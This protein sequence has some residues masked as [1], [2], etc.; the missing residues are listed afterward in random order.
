[1]Y[2]KSIYKKHFLLCTITGAL[3]FSH[4]SSAYAAAPLREVSKIEAKEGK[5]TFLG[6][7]ISRDRISNVDAVGKDSVATVTK[8]EMISEMIS[9]SATKGG[10]INAKEINAKTMI[11][12]LQIAD[13][14]INLEDSVVDV[15]GN[16]TSYGISFGFLSK[17]QTITFNE[18]ILTNTKL[19]VKD[20]IGIVGPLSSGKVKLKNSE[21]RSDVLLQNKSMPGTDPVT[22]TLT[23]DRS[24][25]E[26]RARTLQSNTTV[27]N[28]NND[29]KWLLKISK[30]EVDN[31][32]I[33]A[34]FNYK[35]LDIKKRAHSTVSVLNL[36]SSSIIFDT[37]IGEQY[38]T[39]TVGRGEVIDTPKLGEGLGFGRA[40]SEIPSKAPHDASNEAPSGAPHEAPSTKAVY[41]ATGSAKIYFNAK[42]SD[43]APK[44]QQKADH[45]LV[46]GDVSGTTAIHFNSLLKN[47][48]SNAEDEDN[49]PLNMRGLSLVQVSGKANEKSFK[50][51][52]GYTTMGG[53]P[54]KY[55]LNVYGP[56]S[57]RGKAHSGQNLLGENKDFWDFRLQSATLDREG[58]IKALV[59]QVASYLVMPNAL[60]SAGLADVNNQNTLLDNAQTT[61]RTKRGIVFSSYGN[62]ITLSSN[63]SPLQYGYG[64]DVRYA[65]LQAGLALTALENQ[66]TTT[67]LGFLGTYGKLAFTPK[68]IE[69]SEKST[70]DKWSVSAYGSIHH[71]KGMYLN[72]F[73]SYGAFKGHITTALIGNTVE[74]DNTNTF[75]ASATVG[76]KLATGTKGLTFEPQAQLVYQ[77]LAFGTFSDVDSFDVNIGDLYQWLV[78]FGGRL[79]QTMLPAEDG[80]AVSVYAK[81][82]FMKTFDNDSVIKIGDIFHLDSMGSAIE[83][84][85]GVNAHL[86]KNVILHADVNYQHK[87]QKAG[88][89]GINFSGGVSYRF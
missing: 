43:G 38:Q 84:G 81:L 73:L 61:E 83:G 78:R 7:V 57:S 71:N 25:L 26:G 74:L 64:A 34:I 75:S 66:D 60:F 47:E 50:L 36:D 24:F 18:A 15:K 79:T 5:K 46:Y 49:V 8:A 16:H 32:D 28:L 77:R 33:L 82:N 68:G 29:S 53:L 31:D 85:L 70:L 59:P 69:G 10:R 42:W 19:L 80:C 88:I 40:L 51:A 37:P 63:R 12:G 87:L 14:L 30:N 39:L 23:A 21:I 11:T 2:K 76:Q 54:Y 86:S 22:F 20:G 48:E 55:T 17:D 56:T 65:A 3:I 27:F 1:M 72:T 67:S 41:N 58:K 35:L 52:N 6:N 45:L 89:S 62:G 4:F 44:E 13:G 9:L